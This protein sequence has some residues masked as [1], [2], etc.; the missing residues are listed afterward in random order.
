MV[1][2]SDRLIALAGVWEPSPISNLPALTAF[3]HVWMVPSGIPNS[4]AALT[5][6]ISLASFDFVIFHYNRH[7]DKKLVTNWMMTI[8][9]KRAFISFNPCRLF[10]MPVFW[11]A[12]FPVSISTFTLQSSTVFP[13]KLSCLAYLAPSEMKY[14]CLFFQLLAMVS[15]VY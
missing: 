15:G 13:L 8:K 1:I 7:E 3:S 10:F 11:Q 4:L 14:I 5:P 9:E 2:S 6:P 12:I